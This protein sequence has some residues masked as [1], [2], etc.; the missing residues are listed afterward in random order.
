M[1]YDYAPRLAAR[2]LARRRRHVLFTLVLLTLPALSLQTA[3]RA[4]DQP[5]AP[6]WL[7]QADR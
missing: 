3:G 7:A 1:P 5:A 6:A 4:A 2:A